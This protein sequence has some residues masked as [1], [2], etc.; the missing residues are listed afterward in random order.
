M[1]EGKEVFVGACSLFFSPENQPKTAT[2]MEG[3][4]SPLVCRK[5][6]SCRGAFHNSNP[7]RYFRR[8]TFPGYAYSFERTCYDSVGDGLSLP[9]FVEI[10]R[11]A[12]FTARKD[13]HV[14]K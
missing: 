11:H 13:K 5:R 7:I 14:P 10:F 3:G 8:K 12:A 4:A 9:F 6:G 2:K 1:K